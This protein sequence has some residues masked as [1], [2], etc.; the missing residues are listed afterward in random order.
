VN[1]SLQHLAL[2]KEGGVNLSWQH[3]AMDWHWRRRV[4]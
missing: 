1:L 2:V 4:A 3:L